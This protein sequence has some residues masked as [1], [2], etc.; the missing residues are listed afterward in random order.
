MNHPKEE[1]GERR[2]IT[3]AI[4]RNAVAILADQGELDLD[5][6]VEALKDAIQSQRLAARGAM[7]H[8]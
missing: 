2:S 6:A 8:G 5:M 7:G 1:K 3:V 4:S